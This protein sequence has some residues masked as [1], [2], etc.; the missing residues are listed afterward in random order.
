MNE[1][2]KNQAINKEKRKFRS[3]RAKNK[4]KLKCSENTYKQN[5]MSH[6]ETHK[7]L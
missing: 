1:M 7:T 3:K 5:K 4:N 6:L 2:N